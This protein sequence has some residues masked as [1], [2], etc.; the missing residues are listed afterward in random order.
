MER[1]AKIMIVLAIIALA[2]FIGLQIWTHHKT[3]QMK[4][5]STAATQKLRVERI[6][7]VEGESTSS[8]PVGREMGKETKHQGLVRTE[9]SVSD[10]THPQGERQYREGSSSQEGEASAEEEVGT[11]WRKYMDENGNVTDWEKFKLARMHSHGWYK[12]EDVPIIYEKPKGD[13]DGIYIWVEYVGKGGNKPIPEYVKERG[14]E[15]T[16]ELNR[17]VEMKDAREMFRITKEL[18]ELYRPYK[19]W[20]RVNAHFGQIPE[21]WFP[22]FEDIYKSIRDS[23]VQEWRAWIDQQERR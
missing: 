16:K 10:L 19:S 9:T 5:K 3:Q 14:K 18:D 1:S 17:A 22:Y 21:S 4:A 6:K 20:V 12:P 23:V 7:R 11:D 2:S 15:L 8:T 13:P